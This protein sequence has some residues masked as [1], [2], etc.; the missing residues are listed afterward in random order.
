MFVSE[1]PIRKIEVEEKEEKEGVL[2]TIM[3]D[4][5]KLFKTEDKLVSTL[6]TTILKL[7]KYKVML[8]IIK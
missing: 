7:M 6:W 1:L 2:S 5:E 8:K 4:M 3:E